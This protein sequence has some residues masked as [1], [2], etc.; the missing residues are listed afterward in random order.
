MDCSS[1]CGLVKHPQYSQVVNQLIHFFTD[2][3]EEQ[4][5]EEEP[6]EN[7]YAGMHVLIPYSLHRNITLQACD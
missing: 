6:D 7:I 3:L 4:D 2:T 5:T 1:Y